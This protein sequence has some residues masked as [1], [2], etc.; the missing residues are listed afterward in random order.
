VARA[1]R[2]LREARRGTDGGRQEPEQL[3]AAVAGLVADALGLPEAGLTT[4]D[5]RRHLAEQQLEA[6]L[7]ERATRWCEACDAARYGAGAG[8][9][10]GLEEE[11]DALVVA[12]AHAL[13]DKRLLP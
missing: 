4:G 13:K 5:L 2:R 7:V 12:L 11:A 8:T 9:L 10:H 3:H 6:A 1:R